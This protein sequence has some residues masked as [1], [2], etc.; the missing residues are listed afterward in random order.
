MLL[1]QIPYSA[2]LWW[3]KTLANRLFHNFGEEN[4]GKL[5]IANISYLS[6][7]RIW[8]GKILAN[9]VRFAKFA[10]AFPC[11]NIVL[12]IYQ[13]NYSPGYILVCRIISKL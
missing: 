1:K 13:P 9:D 10:K 3:G 6:E 11:Q 5:T 4:V 2:K 12:Y 8:L 7:S